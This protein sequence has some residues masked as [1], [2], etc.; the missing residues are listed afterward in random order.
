MSNLYHTPIAFAAFLNAAIVNTPL[1][2][3]DQ[4]ID[5]F[6]TGNNTFNILSVGAA[7]SQELED[8][9]LALTAS[10][11]QMD[12]EGGAAS[13]SLETIISGRAGEFVFLGITNATRPITIR[14]GIGNIYL[15]GGA[16]ITLNATTQ[17]FMLFC[18][19]SAWIDFGV[20]DFS[21]SGVILLASSTAQNIPD[22]TNTAY[23]FNVETADTDGYFT[24][25]QSTRIT[26]PSSGRYQANASGSFVANATG[27]RKVF[28]R[29]NGTTELAGSTTPA[30]SG[31][32][33]LLCVA[34]DYEF[35]A[36]DYLE[37]VAYQNSTSTLSV[38]S[39]SFFAAEKL[40]S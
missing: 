17:Q 14:H 11:I 13:D 27:Y 38:G 36:G 9:A 12:T 26:I 22:A 3:L 18:T 23:T 5:G 31:L 35:T 28:I 25:S 39:S 1:S 15:R 21:P 2:Q 30:F 32:N 6:R 4:A 34:V 24:L 20:Q 10:N 19:G 16:D 33:P 40:S 7:D 8:N 29:L 37:L